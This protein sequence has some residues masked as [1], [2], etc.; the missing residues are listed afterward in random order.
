[1]DLTY[2][3]REEFM[4]EQFDVKNTKEVIVLAFSLGKGL[5][6]AKENDGKI[7]AMDMML[8]IPVFTKFGP[9]FEDINLIPKEM[10]DLSV[11]ESKEIQ[12][13]ILAEFG[14][15]VDQAKLIEQVDLGIRAMISIYE[16][17][18]SLK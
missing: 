5:K 13:L 17:V 10:K 2:I 1:M 9:A 12:S 4:S 7:D 11:E 3:P 14:E 16:F 15:L 18:K 8:L 6:E